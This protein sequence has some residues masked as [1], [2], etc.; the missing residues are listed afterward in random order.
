MPAYHLV[1]LTRLTQPLGRILPD[2][3]E[4]PQAGF[5]ALVV[6][7]DQRPGRE[8]LDWV[9]HLGLGHPVA[10]YH[11]RGRFQREPTRK[12]REPAEDCLL[13]GSEQPVAPVER[14]AHRLLAIW[15]AAPAVR[16]QV[17]LRAEPG[18]ELVRAQGAQPRR[19][20]FDGEGKTVE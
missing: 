17:E 13:V 6:E 10:R 9:D 18:G 5:F 2:R 20:E 14:G 12:D 15:T 8:A 7:L 19:D 3:L 1:A 16:E 11:V 4:H